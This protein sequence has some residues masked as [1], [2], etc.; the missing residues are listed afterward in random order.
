MRHTPA[1]LAAIV[2]LASPAFAQTGT[3]ISVNGIYQTGTSAVSSTVAFTAN[4]EP[5]SF[6]SNFPVK[7]GQGLDAGIRVGIR[8]AIGLSLG[9]S[10]FKASGDAAITAQIPHPFFFNQ[11][12]SISGTASLAREETTTRV[13]LVVSS[14]GGKKLQLAGYVGAALFA[15]KQDIVDSVTYT[16]AYP[17]DTAAFGR[18]TTRQVSKS[19]VGIA[20][21][22]DASFFFAK[23]V[24]IGVTAGIVQATI[25][26]A[27]ID[28]STI[29][30]SA[31]GTQLGAGL[32]FRF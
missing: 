2:L 21:G 18:A 6:T 9:I 22:V 13:A 16:D 23:N 17:Y 26:V 29:S 11:P 30:L 20:A 27:A 32:R 19:K 3:V 12:R 5:A 10:S 15:V 25:P 1:L 4:A 14:P 24:G 7:A 28:G 8:G 31:G